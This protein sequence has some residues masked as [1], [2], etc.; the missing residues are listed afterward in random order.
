VLLD[1]CEVERIDPRGLGAMEDLAAASEAKSVKITLRGINV[2]VYKVL[3]LARLASRFT[4][5]N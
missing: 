3:K 5:L 1:F 2:D 4:I